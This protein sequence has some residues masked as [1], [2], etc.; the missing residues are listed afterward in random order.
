MFDTEAD[1][2]YRKLNGAKNYLSMIGKHQP[3]LSD[4]GRLTIVNVKTQI[5]YQGSPGSKNYHDNG[6]FDVALAEVI[7]SRFTELKEAA[8]ALMEQDAERALL[9]EEN[10]IKARLEKIRQIKE[11]KR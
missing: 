5:H 9:N 6:D 7:H 4:T 8:I 11:T 1:I 3:H 10:A 2:L